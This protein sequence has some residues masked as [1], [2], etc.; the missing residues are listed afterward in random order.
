MAIV[1]LMAKTTVRLSD[2]KGRSE[3]NCSSNLNR[4]QW[5]IYSNNNMGIRFGQTWKAHIYKRLHD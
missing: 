5:Q 4:R 1:R 3:D 2:G